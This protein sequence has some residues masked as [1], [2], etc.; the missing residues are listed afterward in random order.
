V[1]SAEPSHCRGRASCIG[2]PTNAG[3]FLTQTRAKNSSAHCCP[4]G[5][6][7]RAKF[8]LE[9]PAAHAAHSGTAS[10]YRAARPQHGSPSGPPSA[11]T[12][13]DA[14]E[15]A[16]DEVSLLVECLFEGMTMDPA[17]LVGNIGDGALRFDLCANPVVAH[18]DGAPAKIDEKFA[19]AAIVVHL[20]GREH[21]SH[22]WADGIYDG[23]T[24]FVVN[25]PRPQPMQRSPLLF[26]RPR[27]ADELAPSMCR[28]F[29]PCHHR[30]S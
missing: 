12:V 17:A 27:R 29:G 23:V 18:H 28:S 6:Q 3:E 4:R 7:W 11:S 30:A 9:L 5:P 10:K 19:G 1:S 2:L 25:P 8:I 16:L 20:S 15:E 21:Q 26:L 22:R 13:F 24:F 14:I